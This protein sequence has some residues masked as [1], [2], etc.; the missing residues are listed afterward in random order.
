M[1]WLV[2]S[3]RHPAAQPFTH[4]RLPSGVE[5]YLSR[6]DITI[7]MCSRAPSLLIQSEDREQSQ[8]SACKSL[9]SNQFLPRSS[10]AG[11]GGPRPAKSKHLL[12][13][14]TDTR[15]VFINLLV[16][17][18]KDTISYWLFYERKYICAAGR[19]AVTPAATGLHHG[20][21][22]GP[23]LGQPDQ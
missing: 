21:S 15:Q 17:N 13:E 8:P 11:A 1:R 23:G 19:P 3:D 2:D 5:A 22:A 18:H 12:S 14:V 9:I 20:S 10:C 4:H 6:E 7:E 16:T